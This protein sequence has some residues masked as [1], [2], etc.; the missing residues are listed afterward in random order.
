[1]LAATLMT[2][3]HN[4]SQ[5]GRD[6]VESN[7]FA[8]INSNFWLILELL[9]PIFPSLAGS[10]TSSKTIVALDLRIQIGA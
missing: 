8:R 5:I 3:S 9:E 7:T 6:N 1:M 4:I 2:R 10:E